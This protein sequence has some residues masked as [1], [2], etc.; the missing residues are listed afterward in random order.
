[1]KFKVQMSSG[2]SCRDYVCDLT[3]EEAIEICQAKNWEDVD[4]NGFVWSL[5][6]VEDDGYKVDE[7]GG[8]D[9]E[10]V[11]KKIVEKAKMVK[12]MEYIARQINDETV[13]MRWLSGGVADGDI[14]YGDLDVSTLSEDDAVWAYIEDDEYF[15]D[16]MDTFLHVIT[17]AKKSGG[18]YCGDVVSKCIS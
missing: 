5:N 17:S 6:Y 7:D 2:W 16:L 8:A 1:M 12:A 18:L 9:V 4:E 10:M 15:A 13:F 14:E 3:E 11:D